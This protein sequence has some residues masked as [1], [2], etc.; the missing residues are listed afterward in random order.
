MGINA[1]VQAE[2]SDLPGATFQI[3]TVQPKPWERTLR[4]LYF[5]W[6][7]ALGPLRRDMYGILQDLCSMSMLMLYKLA[8]AVAFYTA[9]GDLNKQ[10]WRGNPLFRLFLRI[11]L[12]C[13]QKIDGSNSSLRRLSS[14]VFSHAS[15][16]IFPGYQWLAGVFQV[17]GSSSTL[18]K[19]SVE[20]GSQCKG[21]KNERK[22]PK[23]KEK[24]WKW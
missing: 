12:R 6:N 17:C 10:V 19:L 22:L 21:E 7:A 20:D 2:T 16:P 23:C 13:I 4:R 18:R 11:S 14:K 3:K 15:K 1:T 8:R 5:T 24:P 9:F